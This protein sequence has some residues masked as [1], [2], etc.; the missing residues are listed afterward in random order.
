MLHWATPRCFR[1]SRE[2]YQ[3]HRALVLA[4]LAKPEHDDDLGNDDA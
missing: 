4:F 3:S 1:F 2:K